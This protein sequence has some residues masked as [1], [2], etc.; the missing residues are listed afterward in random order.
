LSGV[1]YESFG[2]L[3]VVLVLVWIKKR[4]VS[5]GGAPIAGGYR[6]N[7]GGKVKKSR[8]SGL[9]SPVYGLGE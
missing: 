9:A 6:Q 5:N 8:A 7:F 2:L 4:D 1:V 3:L